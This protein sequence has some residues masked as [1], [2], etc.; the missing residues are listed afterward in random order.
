LKTYGTAT[1][2][3]G[4][5]V[6]DAEPHVV[7]RLKRVFG[8]VGKR[9][10]GKIRI[11][12]TF[13]TC[14]DLAWFLERYPL[15]VTPRDYLEKRA[16]EHRERES[17]VDKLLSGQVTARDFQLAIPP[18]EYQRV[19]A[20]LALASR[21][22][23]L[24]DDLGLGK[25]CSSICMLSDARTRPALVVAPT[26]LQRQWAEE[27]ARFAP[28]LETHILKKG[29]PYDYT[30]AK[31][32]RKQA[33]GQLSL[34]KPHPDVLICNYHKLAGWVDALTP[35]LKSII[36]D[37]VADLRR[38]PESAKGAAALQLAESVDYRLGTSATPIY[39]YGGEIF[40]ILQAV[41]PGALGERTEFLEEWCDGS[42]G[43]KPRLK[44]PAA[45][46]A[47]LRNEGLMLRRTREDVGREL[48]ELTHAP[49]TV[50]ADPDAL[51]SIQ[52]SAAELAKVILGETDHALEKGDQFRAGG[53]LDGLVRQA[54]GIAKA[55]YVADFVRMLVESGERVVLYGWHRAVYKI[56]Q[57]RLSGYS[58]ALYTGSESESQK[59]EAKRRFCDGETPILIISLRAG[60]GLDGL[61]YS[62]C[63]TVVFGELDWSPAVHQQC[64][65]RVHRD[66]QTGSVIAYYLIADVG[67]D[68]IIAD[69]L[70]VKKAQLYG[71]RDA[72]EDVIEN[73]DAGG[74]NVRA[75]AEQYLR[76]G[77]A[78]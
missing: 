66:G 43:D 10:Q 36:F 8:S 67:A 56:W 58:P 20:E 31:R 72:G 24:A 17:V 41:R 57:D 55:P 6:I 40:H 18:R 25:T 53:E 48:P 27:I 78:A 65:G 34:V 71:V 54:T 42:G 37:E 4:K 35:V 23:L 46:G 21:G 50:D 76:K 70:Q 51:N 5:W 15:E 62:G 33:P 16:A 49:H 12:D 30:D 13:D 1:L 26:H 60:A 22:L 75:L 3:S 64:V 7:M 19:A 44:E 69:V 73:Y 77:R 61:Q 47:H 32:R 59:T 28:H 39:N 63:R 68:P 52:S 9:R 45:F 2:K 11:K 29:T 74:A 14:R 38:G